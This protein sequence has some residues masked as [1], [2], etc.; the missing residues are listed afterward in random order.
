MS[1]PRRSIFIVKKLY[2]APCCPLC[3]KVDKAP[4]K[5]RWAHPIS[6]LCQA[7]KLVVAT[8]SILL[9]SAAPRVQSLQ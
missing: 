8:K 2:E 3:D 6:D 4:E 7:Q 9:A 5:V 1:G